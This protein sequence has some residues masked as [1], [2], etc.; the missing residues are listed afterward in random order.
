VPELPAL[1]EV[2]APP[3]LPVEPPGVPAVPPPEVPA[4]PDVAQTLAAVRAQAEAVQGAACAAL[5]QPLPAP[6]PPELA[7]VAC[8]PLPG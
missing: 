4:V 5:E 8:A 6:L 7:G 2:P 3:S 1:P